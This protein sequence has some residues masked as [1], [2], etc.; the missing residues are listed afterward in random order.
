[1]VITNQNLK[2]QQNCNHV[3]EVVISMGVQQKGGG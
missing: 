3:V 1:M 2:Q